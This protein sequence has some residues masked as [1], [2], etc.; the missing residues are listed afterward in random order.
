MPENRNK[1]YVCLQ[2][3]DRMQFWS[4]TTVDNFLILTFFKIYL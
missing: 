4:T 2:D 3:I 1:A